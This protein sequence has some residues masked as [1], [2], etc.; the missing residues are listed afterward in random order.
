MIVNDGMSTSAGSQGGR[1]N[2]WIDGALAYQPVPRDAEAPESLYLD[3][4]EGRCDEAVMRLFAGRLMGEPRLLSGYP[5][6]VGLEARLARRYGIRTE[7]VVVCTGGDDAI[8]RIVSRSISPGDKALVYEPAFSMY[9]VYTAIRGGTV[10][11]LP[12]YEADA[13]PLA[14]SLELVGRCP[15]LS[16]VCLASPANPIGNAASPADIARLAEACRAGGRNLLIDAAYE[17]F[18]DQDCSRSMAQAANCFIVGTF[19]KYWGLAGLRVGWA[20]APDVRTADQLRAAG[21]PYPVSALAL[22]AADS[23]LDCEENIRQQADMVKTNRSNL[24][25]SLGR[26]GCRVFPSQANFVFAR[27]DRS[28]ALC[29]ALADKNI[30]VRSWPETP[31]LSDALRITVPAAAADC[32]KLLDALNGMEAV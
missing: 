11:S 10:V 2:R 6:A 32:Q 4:N 14:S 19:S 1:R 16:L 22:A 31:G 18:A 20:I 29:A 26:L 13:F 28:K 5:S 17:D 25:Q 24:I 21:G 3:A 23:A 9:G 30:Y 12:W 8:Q 27:S 15:S 7:R